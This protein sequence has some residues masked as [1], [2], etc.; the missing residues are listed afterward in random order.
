MGRLAEPE[1]IVEFV[2]GVI[3]KT[4]QDLKKKKILITAGPTHEPIDPVRFIATVRREKWVL[5]LPIP[6]HWRGADVTLISGQWRSKPKECKRIDVE[7]AVKCMSSDGAFEET[8]Y[9]HN[10]AAVA[11]Y[12][13][14]SPAKEKIKKTS[15]TDVCR[16]PFTRD[17]LKTL[18]KKNR[19][20][21]SLVGFA[22]ETENELATR[23]KITE[24]KS[25]P[26]CFEFCKTERG[27]IGSDTNVVTL[28]DSKGS[29]KKLPMMPKFDVALEI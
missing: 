19:R 26:D 6:L 1:T 21:N 13:P 9:N 11:D 7:T 5:R 29:L 28:I 8:G 3:E 14:A 12:A 16:T 2:D 17:I 4:P 20:N 22:L 18:V 10:V 27:R 24:K 23:N 25:R 15:C